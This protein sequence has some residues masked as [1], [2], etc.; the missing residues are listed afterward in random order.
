MLVLERRG[1]GSPRG[2]E[3][4]RERRE[5]PCADNPPWPRV[6]K[7]RCLG[8]KEHDFVVD[9]VNVVSPNLHAQ[10]AA[11]HT[12]QLVPGLQKVHPFKR[13][14]Y[15]KPPRLVHDLAVLKYCLCLSAPG[16]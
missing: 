4:W 8:S 10:Y 14:L 7:P 5:L 3:E 13:H 1:W 11:F 9:S 6:G 15:H 16:F 2:K 12:E